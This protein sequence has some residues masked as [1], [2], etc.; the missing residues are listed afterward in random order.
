MK[1]GKKPG[2]L[3]RTKNGLLGRTYHSDRPVNGKVKV[4]LLN[5][6]FSPRNASNTDRQLKMLCDPN[7]LKLVGYI[8]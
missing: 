3:V 1:N 2:M 7:T 8:D 6:D 4:Y 5:E